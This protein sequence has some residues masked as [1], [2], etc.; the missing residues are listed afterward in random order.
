MLFFSVY[1]QLNSHDLLYDFWSVRAIHAVLRT[2]S[3]AGCFR[4]LFLLNI[5]S[6]FLLFGSIWG[7]QIRVHVRHIPDTHSLLKSPVELPYQMLPT[8]L[9]GIL[10]IALLWNVF[11][12]AALSLIVITSV[13]S[14]Y[15]CILKDPIFRKCPIEKSPFKTKYIWGDQANKLLFIW[16]DALLDKFHVRKMWKLPLCNAQRLEPEKRYAVQKYL[17]TIIYAQNFHTELTHLGR[18]QRLKQRNYKRQRWKWN[19][20]SKRK[21]QQPMDADA[22]QSSVQ[23]W[24]VERAPRRSH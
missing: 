19:D 11:M 1:P 13:T 17:C 16:K 6:H 10:R 5:L 14:H 7:A 9:L 20:S 2:F 4:Q 24:N 18:K 23:I 21:V 15:V 3:T 8:P 22:L 12:K